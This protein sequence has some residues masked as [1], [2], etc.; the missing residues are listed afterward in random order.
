MQFVYQP[1]GAEAKRWEFEPNKLMSPEAEAIERHTGLTFQEWGQ[2]VTKGSILALH[3]L[4]FVLL[5]RSDPT[6]KWDAVQFCMDDLDFQLDD[7]ETA[8]A[9]GNLESAAAVRELTADEQ[10]TLD[11]LRAGQPEGEAP[12]D[13][14]PESSDDAA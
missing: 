7:E 11:V 2:A 9:I 3:G 6:L 12:K 8:Q 13:E 4:L 10:R 1:E 14:A 5:K